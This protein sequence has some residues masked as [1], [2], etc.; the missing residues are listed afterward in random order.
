M[1]KENEEKDKLIKFL[2]RFMNKKNIE[3]EIKYRVRDEKKFRNWLKKHTKKLYDKKQ[4]DE[5]FTPSHKNYFDEE[6]PYEYFRLRKTGD[7]YST[8]YKRFYTIP[9]TREHSHCDEYETDIQSGEQFRKLLIALGFKPIVVVDKHRE[10]YEYKDFEIT[11]D[12]V[13]DVGTVC[14]IELQGKYSSIKEARKV[15]KSMAE[16]IGFSE[17][18]RDD[19]LKLGYA[20]LMA[21]K[22]GIWHEK[23]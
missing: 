15:I 22:K 5:Y 3:V 20:F 19:D 13:K 1:E 21:K 16:E 23:K 9:G 11:I 14:E 6:F 4:I 2:L 12:K 8:A 7:Q 10:A 18:D 17:D